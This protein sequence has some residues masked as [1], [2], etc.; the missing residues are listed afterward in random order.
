MVTKVDSILQ[1]ILG[2]WSKS[3]GMA[4]VVLRGNCIVG[5]G[6]AGV[7]R[8]GAADCIT[9]EDRFHL[10]SCGKAMAATLVAMLVEEGRL[11]WTDTL[12]GIFA[13]TIK[14]IHPAWEKVTLPKLLAHCAG[15]RLL[16]HRSLRSRLG[17]PENL[18]NQ[19]LEIARYTLSRAP[20]SAP[21]AKFTWLGYSN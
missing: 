17:S 20:D 12:G 14:D 5:E 21:R 4:A 3:F 11:S 1:P 6:V 8:K 13:G 9:L 10:G 7:R 16:A 15:M 18:P 19:R 2:R